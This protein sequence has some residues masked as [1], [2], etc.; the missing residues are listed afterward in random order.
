[1]ARLLALLPLIIDLLLS[2]WVS[3]L[4]SLLGTRRD[5]ADDV[6]RY[7][8]GEVDTVRLRG[9]SPYLVHARR[10]VGRSHLVAA[11]A[12]ER[13]VSEAAQAS[14]SRTR[15]CPACAPRTRR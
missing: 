9:V 3:F 8:G 7:V 13:L 14:M 12:A 1:M 15:R 6:E 4:C 2:G 5:A 11:L 10:L